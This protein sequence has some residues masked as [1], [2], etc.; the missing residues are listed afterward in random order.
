MKIAWKTQESAFATGWQTWLGP[1]RVPTRREALPRQPTKIA[2]MWRVFLPLFCEKSTSCPTL[3]TFIFYHFR[4]ID[5]F[6]WFRCSIKMLV[7]DN[8]PQ[9]TNEMKSRGKRSKEMHLNIMYFI[10]LE[11]VSLK[12]M[13][14]QDYPS[15]KWLGMCF[16]K[17]ATV[18]SK[19]VFYRTQIKAS[20]RRTKKA[21]LLFT[22]LIL[23]VKHSE[24]FKHVQH[25]NNPVRSV[26]FR[27]EW[28]MQEY[29]YRL[30]EFERSEDLGIWEARGCWIFFVEDPWEKNTFDWFHMHVKIPVCV[31]CMIF[32]I[33]HSWWK[34]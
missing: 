1:G 22:K 17:N 6:E 32:K 11:L 26:S 3:A 15:I 23:R 18:K 7:E 2:E 14:F 33:H 16:V 20:K 13:M 8:C 30:R 21:L 12:R 25:F 34:V 29:S 4:I 9:N 28:L 27:L 10:Q 24:D 31:Q 5:G 19:H